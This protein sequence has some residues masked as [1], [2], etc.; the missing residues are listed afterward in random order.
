V[1]ETPTLNKEDLVMVR[2]ITL[3][4]SKKRQ[5]EDRLVGLQ[6]DMVETRGKISEI[7]KELEALIGGRTEHDLQE[8]HQDLLTGPDIPASGI[9]PHMIK[10]LAAQKMPVSTDEIFDVVKVQVSNPKKQIRK[11]SIGSYLS[12]LKC[13]VSIKKKD[14]IEGK[15][16]YTTPGWI[17]NKEALK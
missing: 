12:N 8:E 13:F 9:V 6:A 14:I 17:L 1:E 3:L 5:A 4:V 7:N 11:K 16:H 10:F 2:E 15:T